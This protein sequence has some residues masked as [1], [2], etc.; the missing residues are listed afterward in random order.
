MIPSKMMLRG[1][2]PCRSRWA[3][4]DTK[5]HGMVQSM[6]RKG[7]CYDNAAAQSFFSSLKN[8]LLLN[9]L[10][11]KSGY[12]NVTPV[13]EGEGFSVKCQSSASSR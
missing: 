13:S 12:L 10:S 3:C 7:N 6:S 1:K 2:P 5:K 11:V 8:E 9:Y 4:R